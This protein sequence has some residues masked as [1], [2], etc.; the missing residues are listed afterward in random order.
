MALPITALEF[1]A[2]AVSIIVFAPL[3]DH[4]PSVVIETDSITST[5]VLSQDAAHS[6]LL[7]A[8]HTLLLRTPAYPRLLAGLTQWRDVRVTH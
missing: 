1:L 8:A 6:P 3:L 4:A 2:L 5:F 7:K